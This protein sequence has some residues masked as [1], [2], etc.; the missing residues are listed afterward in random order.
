M[1]MKFVIVS[2]LI[3]L[4]LYFPAGYAMDGSRKDFLR[5]LRKPRE[6]TKKVFI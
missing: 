2:L 3:T 6:S 1:D 4:N 5:I